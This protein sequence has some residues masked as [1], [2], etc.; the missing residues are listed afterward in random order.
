MIAILVILA[1]VAAA[2]IWFLLREKAAVLPPG[3][4]VYSDTSRARSANRS[5]RTASG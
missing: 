4:V 5:P 3:Q 1:A 2:A